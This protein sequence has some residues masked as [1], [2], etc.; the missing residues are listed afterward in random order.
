MKKTIAAA[1]GALLLL[2]AGSAL[3]RTTYPTT[4]L[5]KYAEP[6]SGAKSLTLG[7]LESPKAA[8]LSRRTVTAKSYDDASKLLY[9]DQDTTSKNGAWELRVKPFANG[10]VTFKVKR[11][12]IGRHATC[13]SG[14]ETISS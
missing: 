4:I 5:E 10:H 3:A 14:T 11:K 9:T 6:T 1:L 12:K 2:G 7:L 8:C 13:Q